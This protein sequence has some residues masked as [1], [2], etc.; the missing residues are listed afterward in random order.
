VH[1]SIEARRPSEKRRVRKI[2]RPGLLSKRYLSARRG[3]PILILPSNKIVE[4]L[5]HIF[6]YRPM[7]QPALN[8]RMR[9]TD[10]CE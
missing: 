6:H 7:R 8:A 3:H 2:V 1:R 10:I 5:S 4:P 9:L